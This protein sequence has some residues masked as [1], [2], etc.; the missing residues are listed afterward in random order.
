MALSDLCKASKRLLLL[1]LLI[2][3]RQEWHC[4]NYEQSSLRHN[5][6]FRW[7]WFNEACDTFTELIHVPTMAELPPEE[8][9]ADV[10]N[11]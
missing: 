6:L 8:T 5:M 1:I 9:Q 11:G 7:T 10:S 2:T 3:A 4:F